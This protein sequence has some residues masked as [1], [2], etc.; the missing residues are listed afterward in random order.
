ML[1]RC[2]DPTLIGYLLS[3]SNAIA[4]Q[5][6]RGLT[7]EAA[8]ARLRESAT[9]VARV[10]QQLEDRAREG[11]WNAATEAEAI[12]AGEAAFAQ[13]E[14]ERARAG[15]GPAPASARKLDRAAL[16]DYLRRRVASGG[17]PVIEDL[18]LLPG[19]RCKLTA[20]ISQRG[21]SQLPETFIFRQDWRGG[22]TDTSVLTEHALLSGVVAGGVRAPR[23]LWAEPDT[24]ALGEPF[25]FLERMPGALAGS[26]FTPPRSPRLALQLAEQLG[27]LHALPIERF[28]KLVPEAKQAPAELAAAIAEFRSMQSSIGLDTRL[29]EAAI[30]WLSQHLADV[31]DALALTHN[32]VGFHN[33]LVQ[34]ESLTALLDWELAAIGHPAADLGYVRPFV[35]L[36]LPWD[37][38]VRAYEAAGGWKVEPRALRFHT[39]WNA[40]RLYGLIMQARANLAARRVNDVEITFACADNVMLLFAALAVELREARAI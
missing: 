14:A 27:R 5:L 16:Q 9:I 19:G 36:M 7:A 22:A 37:E 3:A 18:R 21:S 2:D 12:L 6:N 11:V 13:G 8:A 33:T 35:P 26:L 23:P 34:G 40:V 10:A 20:L 4:E 24:A 31:G 38:F 15:L 25:I 32:D 39:I 29:I 1:P 28:Q 17:S 30:D